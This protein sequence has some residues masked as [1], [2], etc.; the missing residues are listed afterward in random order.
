MTCAHKNILLA[1][2]MSSYLIS[3]QMK[4]KGTE[5]NQKITFICMYLSC[6]LVKQKK[7]QMC[8]SLDVTGAMNYVRQKIDKHIENNAFSCAVHAFTRTPKWK[9]CPKIHHYLFCIPHI[10]TH[11]PIP[12]LWI[13]Q[14]F[15]VHSSLSY[16]NVWANWCGDYFAMSFML[17]S[18]ILPCL[19]S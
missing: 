19:C 5:I 7:M 2:K 4:S 9:Y 13:I 12:L 11:T 14:T 6:P 16:R 3:W 17:P 1:V 15:I 18:S 8:C 10:K